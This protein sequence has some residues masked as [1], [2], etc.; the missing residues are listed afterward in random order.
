MTDFDFGK[1]YEEL[2]LGTPRGSRHALAVLMESGVAAW[3]MVL[4]VCATDPARSGRAPAR[5]S[6]PP[7]RHEIV[8]I[9]TAM[10]V[11]RLR[12]ASP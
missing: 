11:G 12:G 4:G 9:L 7:E 8:R 6:A 1:R 5:P 10:V 2:R 3:I